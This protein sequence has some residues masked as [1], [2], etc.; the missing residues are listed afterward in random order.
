MSTAQPTVTAELIRQLAAANGLALTLER[1]ATLV[2][3]L[4]AILATDQA[5]AALPIHTLPITGLPWEAPPNTLHNT[6][7]GESLG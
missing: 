2:P 5:I 3:A 7:K 1:A 6:N 4:Q